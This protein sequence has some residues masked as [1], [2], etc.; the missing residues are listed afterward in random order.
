MELDPY[1][2]YTRYLSEII[3]NCNYELVLK[4]WVLVSVWILFCSYV[5]IGMWP[6]SSQV[7]EGWNRSFLEVS[8]NIRKNL[9][10]LAHHITGGKAPIQFNRELLWY[11]LCRHLWHRW[12]SGDDKDSIDH[13]STWSKLT[14]PKFC[15]V[16]NKTYTETENC[17]NA[18]F[19]DIDDPKGYHKDN[20]QCHPPFTTNVSIMTTLGSSYDVLSSFIHESGQDRFSQWEKRSRE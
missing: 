15:S 5:I 9:C 1:H 8:R 16:W 2:C 3:N 12:F 14:Q 18:K 20:L 19:V 10:Y 4:Y 17:H 11:Q 13:W 6:N 7:T